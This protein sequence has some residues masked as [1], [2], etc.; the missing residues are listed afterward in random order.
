MSEEPV[1]TSSAQGLID[2]AKAIILKPAEEW[3]VIEAEP[4][5][6]SDVL[7]K[8]AVPLAAIPPIASLI[9]GQL[10]GYSALGLSY[11]PSLLGALGTAVIQFFM[12]LVSLFLLSFIANFLASKFGGTEDRVRAF[13]LVAYSFTASWVAGI[14]GL[15]PAIGF[16]AILGLYSIYLFY[17]GATPLMKVPQEKAGGYTAV[18]VLATV[19]IYLAA[20]AITGT[21]TAMFVGNPFRDMTYSSDSGDLSGSVNVPGVG[22][23]DV[24]KMEQAAKRMEDQANGKAKPVDSAALQALLPSSIG[25]YARTAQ[26]STAVGGMGNVEG[27]YESGDNRFDLRITDTNALGAL[28][29][30]GVAMGMEQSRQDAE[31]YEK[32]GVVD[33]RMQTEKWN[34]PGNRGTFGIMVGERFMVEAEGT[35]PGIDV[36]KAAVASVNQANLI[37]LAK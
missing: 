7:T 27:T 36:L 15:I 33:G 30:M 21:I 32:T 6:I 3:P 29:G 1:S 20:L 12:A 18:T 24:G 26:Q 16:L 25:N 13:K 5:T 37:A 10:F 23:I 17:T 28:A 11:R 8:Y 19:L 22:T 4:A 35:V 2:R 9:G 14:F 34:K 31:G